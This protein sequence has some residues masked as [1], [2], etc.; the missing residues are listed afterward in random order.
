VEHLVA[1]NFKDLDAPVAGAGG[2][3]LAVI[4]EL[5]IVN[6]VRVARFKAADQLSRLMRCRR[7]GDGSCGAD[8]IQPNKF[9]F[10]I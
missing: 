7:H 6:H 5:G 3:F 10:F 2:H 9:L 1:G 8:A 4:I